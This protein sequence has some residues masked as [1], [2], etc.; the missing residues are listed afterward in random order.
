LRFPKFFNGEKNDRGVVLRK[1]TFSY[2]ENFGWLGVFRG[3][4]DFKF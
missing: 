4:R 2:K 1:K 3:F